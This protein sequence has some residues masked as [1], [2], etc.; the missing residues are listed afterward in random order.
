[1]YI[2]W[3]LW[4]KQAVYCICLL[5]RDDQLESPELDFDYISPQI[6]QSGLSLRFQITP[7]F[8]E[9]KWS[10]FFL[11]AITRRMFRHYGQD[12]EDEF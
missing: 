10:V 2:N 1:M 11:Q 5:S 7:N 9:D 8:H 3:P 6:G 4:L 12:E